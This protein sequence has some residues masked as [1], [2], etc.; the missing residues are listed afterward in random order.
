MSVFRRS[1][2][3]ALMAAFALMAVPASAWDSIVYMPSWAGSVSQIQ[4]PY[5]THVNYAFVLPNGNGTLQA[6]PNPSKLQQLVSTAHANG[7]KVLVSLGGWNGGNDSGFEQL[8]GN[9]SARTTFTNAIINLVNQY[10][11]DGIDID[12]EYP[13]PGT[14]GNNAT[15]VFQQV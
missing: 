11:L 5:V 7:K 3:V 6:V 2:I 14:S 9:A 1:S 15:L 12:W 4:W 13:D 8:A 10:G